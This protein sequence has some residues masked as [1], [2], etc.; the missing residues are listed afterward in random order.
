[1]TLQQLSVREPAAYLV[2]CFDVCLWY[3]EAHCLCLKKIIYRYRYILSHFLQP[4]DWKKTV[5]QNKP[6]FRI[7]SCRVVEP[8]PSILGRSRSQDFGSAPAPIGI[9]VKKKHPRQL[10]LKAVFPFTLYR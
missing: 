8:D 4:D 7:L 9:K 10:K 5:S 1:M 2:E 3:N 6:P